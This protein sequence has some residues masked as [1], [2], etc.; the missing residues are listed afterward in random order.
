MRAF[1]FLLC[2]ILPLDAIAA[3]PP[4]RHNVAYTDDFVWYL[5]GRLTTEL[6]EIQKRS[7]VYAGMSAGDIEDLQD[8][9][10]LLYH[11][12]LLECGGPLPKVAQ[13]FEIWS[14]MPPPKGADLLHLVGVAD[15]DFWPAL[16]EWNEKNYPRLLEKSV[17]PDYGFFPECIVQPFRDQNPQLMKKLKPLK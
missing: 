9:Y 14:T 12:L 1:F 11:N 5:A 2:F 13:S 16:R 10:R 3:K 15:K 6:Q 17:T 8:Q 4:Q 7:N